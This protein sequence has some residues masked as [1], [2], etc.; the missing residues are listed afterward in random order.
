M[1]MRDT[2][3]GP[4]ERLPLEG[5]T[6][7]PATDRLFGAA[8][9]R[10]AAASRSLTELEERLRRHFPRVSVRAQIGDGRGI[11]TWFVYRDGCWT[12]ERPLT[13]VPVRAERAVVPVRPVGTT[14][15]PSLMRTR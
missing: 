2:L 1:T 14:A 8:V 4:G 13:A 12:S 9:R 7:N 11:A 15:P 5:I 6:I 3:S 10:A